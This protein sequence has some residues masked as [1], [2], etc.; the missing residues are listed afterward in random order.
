MK[1]ALNSTV[2]RSALLSRIQSGP[3][4]EQRGRLGGG[5][6]GG[7]SE[8]VQQSTLLAGDLLTAEKTKPPVQ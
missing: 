7:L 1:L 8:P 2:R 3:L 6:S 4:S 5:G